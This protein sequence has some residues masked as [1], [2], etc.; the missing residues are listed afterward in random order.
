M[1]APIIVR[2]PGTEK[3]FRLVRSRFETGTS[4]T[5]LSGKS[6][7]LQENLRATKDLFQTL[8]NGIP[9]RPGYL[10]IEGQNRSGNTTIKVIHSI[11]NL[12]S[13]F[14]SRKFFDKWTQLIKEN[15]YTS[16][17]IQLAVQS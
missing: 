1:T 15:R 7:E 12:R 3:S 6:Y 2:V 5:N 10:I 13:E 8:I 17:Q 4:E 14:R 9:E 11:E 16:I